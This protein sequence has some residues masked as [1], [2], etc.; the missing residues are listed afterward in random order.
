MSFPTPLFYACEPLLTCG[1][2]EP[3]QAI[4]RVSTLQEQDQD[5]AGAHSLRCQAAL[6]GACGHE[7]R[8]AHVHGS[9]GR[10]HKI[11]GFS[12]IATKLWLTRELTGLTASRGE[13]KATDEILPISFTPDCLPVTPSQVGGFLYRGEYDAWATALRM[14]LCGLFESRMT[15]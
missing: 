4:L 2:Q 11:V 13:E 3:H 10:E 14:L 6:P 8:L 7:H 1:R 9:I 12:K 5:R 15:T